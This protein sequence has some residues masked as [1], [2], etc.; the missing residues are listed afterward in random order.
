VKR[1][2]ASALLFILAS[3]GDSDLDTQTVRL[4][5]Q[6]LA[7]AST[8][9]LTSS[10]SFELGPPTVK[11]TWQHKLSFLIPE[12]TWVKQG[13]KVIGFDAQS[14]IS[15][16]RDL[17][18]SLATESQRLES[19]ALDNQQEREQLKL[20]LAEAKMELDKAE[21]KATNIDD[22]MAAI[23]VKK[24]RIDHEIRKHNYEMAAFRQENRLAQMKIDREVV[25]S[26]VQRL[27]A[28]VNEQRKAIAAMEV[29][30]P[31]DGIVVY[32]IDPE[33]NKPAEGDQFSSIQ[34][35][36]EIPDLSHLIVET[37]IPEQ[38][39]YKVSVGDRVELSFDA[40]PEQRFVGEVESLGKIVRV[41][42][43]EEPSKVFDA[44][45]KIDN[46]D[47]EKMRPGMAARLSIIQGIISD[48]VSVPQTAIVY[49]N[50]KSY[51]RVNGSFGERLKRVEI[52]ALRE[53][54]AIIS[55]G[56]KDGDEVIL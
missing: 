15:R 50:D 35:V 46:P 26:E 42:S 9:E 30:A 1:V 7:I 44:I 39:A 23:E 10:E 3:C 21:A 18:N 13:Q 49:Q 32:K 45:I 28:E 4:G 17:Q 29:K 55:S 38:I 27:S 54:Q 31:R 34:K 51:V 53:G 48:A 12:G 40:I 2:L 43:R 5:E 37:T 25:E 19:Q 6:T 41:K 47:P 20:D 24:L 56:L 52:E 22:L 33:G 14:Q 11:Y 8:G 16:L 36:V